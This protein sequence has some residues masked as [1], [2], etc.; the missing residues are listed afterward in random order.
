ML[1]GELLRTACAIHR[2]PHVIDAVAAGLRSK[3]NRT[4]IVCMDV[5]GDVLR[6]FGLDIFQQARSRPFHD[7]AKVRSPRHGVER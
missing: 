6:D 3:S 1:H 7:I 5:L 4:R 2:V